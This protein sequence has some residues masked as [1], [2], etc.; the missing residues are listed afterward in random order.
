MLCFS[1]FFFLLLFLFF[2][3]MLCL[4]IPWWAKERAAGGVDMDWNSG[5]SEFEEVIRNGFRPHE[6]HLNK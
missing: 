6:I 1:F 2:V 4:R 5:S 3:F